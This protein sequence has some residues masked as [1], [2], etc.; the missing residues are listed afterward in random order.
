MSTDNPGNPLDYQIVDCD[1]HYYEPD[2]CFTRHIESKFKERTVRVDRSRED[3]VGIM[4]VDDT[5]LSFFSVG[6]GDYVG[7]PGAMMDFFKGEAGTQNM[8]NMNPIQVKDY[9][10]FQ[11]R[12]QRLKKMDE[13]AVEA[14]V[15]IPTLG[16]GVEYQLRQYPDLI[17]PSLRAYNRWIE[18]D[19]GYAAGD[20][21]FSTPI[22]SLLDVDEAVKELDRLVDAGVRLVHITCG[23]IEGRSPAD[24]HFDPFWARMN[25]TETRV[26][27]HIGETGCNQM[28]AAPWGEPATPPS[29]R[30]SAFNTFVGIGER[31]VMDT[32]ASM[33][34]LN[35]F[36]R[37]PKLRMLAV[38]FGSDWVPR[39]VKGMDKIQ[40]MADHKTRW[41]YGAPKDKLSE[42]FKRHVSVVP[43]YEDDLEALVA[44]IGPDSIIN[45]SDYPHPEGLE[46]PMTMADYMKPFGEENTRKMMRD[47][48][49]ELLR[50]AA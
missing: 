13:Q 1:N 26:V 24:T 45:G 36:E 23:P 47:N 44:A 49:C 18:E 3:G 32:L 33:L 20:R 2:D 43:F 37:F 31:S 7:P 40:A 42:V 21:V 41:R 15:A 35:L 34:F 4:L 38:E 25:E 16:V 27:L 22:I 14:M 9:P 28:Y 19:W 5:R 50:I 12:D 46:W 30:Y 11:N 48:A 39:F 6:V 29:H 17:Y 10:E 8:V